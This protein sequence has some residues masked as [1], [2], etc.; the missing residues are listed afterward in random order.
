[1]SYPKHEDWIVKRRMLLFL[2]ALLVLLTVP[3]VA[4]DQTQI[5]ALVRAQLTPT[6]AQASTPRGAIST[7]DYRFSGRWAFGIAVI[8]APDGIHSEP[9]LRLFIAR[10]DTLGA[11]QVAL[12]Y[13]PRFYTWLTRLPQDLLPLAQRHF[14][15]EAAPQAF[16]TPQGI[17][18]ARLGL[19]FAVNQ[20][21]TLFGGPHGNGGNSVRP[22]SSLDLGILN[23]R[24]Q[25]QAA[26]DGVVWRSSDSPIC[27]H[28]SCGWLA[29]RLLSP[30][31]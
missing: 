17:A 18:D 23:T 7:S 11:W 14:L 21:W 22:W 1:M 8:R 12:E 20:T 16:S 5:D 13:S 25:V 27:P 29:D 9:E 10:R 2:I 4:Q 26:R 30:D 31:Q 19:P 24:V 28:R 15:I 6:I 3:S